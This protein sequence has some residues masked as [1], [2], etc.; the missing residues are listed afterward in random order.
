MSSIDLCS[1]IERNCC[2]SERYITIIET[3][4]RILLLLNDDEEQTKST[5]FCLLKQLGQASRL[6][7]SMVEHNENEDDQL[8]MVCHRSIV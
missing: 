8:E 6:I 2:S 7:I 3:I 5:H 4:H 1:S